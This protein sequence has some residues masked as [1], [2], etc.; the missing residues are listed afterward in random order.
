MM[1]E[2]VF[3]VSGIDTGCGKTR[4]TGLLAKQLKLSGVN[5]ITQK[6]IQTGCKG[7]SEDILE[8]RRLMESNLFPEDEKGITCPYVF[9]HASSPHLAAKIE[10][11]IIDF[12]ILKQS[13]EN[14]SNRFEI[15]L[16]EGAGGLLVPLNGDYLIADY[17]LENNYPLI[18]VASSKLGSINH[19]LLSLDACLIRRL[20]LILVVY[21]NLPG[22]DE[23]IAAD[24]F[25]V[26][27][28]YLDKIFPDVPL[29]HCSA[30]AAHLD[31]MIKNLFRVQ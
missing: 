4:V 1:K 7:L 9:S 18:L 26:L 10:D 8:H 28:K 24:S 5:V 6:L 16:I 14:L 17:I 21:N 3:F 13:T 25:Y 27:Q 15:V 22:D 2:N 29:C 12:N 23:I 30:L 19:T 20:K 31:S 11:K